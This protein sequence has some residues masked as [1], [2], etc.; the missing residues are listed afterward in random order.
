MNLT[1]SGHH[2]EVTPALR[3]YVTTK[4]D[5]ITRHFDQVVDVKVLLTV[6]NKL[7][8]RERRQKAECTIHVKGN[9]IFA[10]SSDKDLYAAFDVLVDKLAQIEVDDWAAHPGPHMTIPRMWELRDNL[11]PYDA[12]YVALAELTGTVLV[13]G[14][15]RIAAAP[16]TRCEIQIT[17]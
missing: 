17:R 8:E 16:G 9:D 13:T 3:N 5:R 11:A 14:D 7:K 1:I 4:L 12:A 2:L 15:E 6:E 10:E